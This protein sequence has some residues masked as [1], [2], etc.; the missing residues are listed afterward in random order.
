MQP[1]HRVESP[2]TPA[3]SHS[4]LLVAELAERDVFARM[5]GAPPLHSC[6]RLSCG[7]EREMEVLRAQLPPALDA[8]RER[9]ARGEAA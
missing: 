6:I 4:R 9:F 8:A 5:P 1:I 2:R 3:L 7:T